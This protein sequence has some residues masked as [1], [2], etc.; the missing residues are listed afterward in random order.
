MAHPIIKNVS[1]FEH[2]SPILSSKQFILGEAH[3]VSVQVGLKVAQI[4]MFARKFFF[5]KIMPPKRK[6]AMPPTPQ[7]SSKSAPKRRRLV[8]QST[9]AIT[10]PVFATARA[11]TKQFLRYSEYVTLNPGIGQTAAYVFS[12]NGIYDPDITGVGHQVR[13][14]DQWMTLYTRYV[15]T[16]AKITVQAAN[17]ANANASAIFGVN[18]TTDTNTSLDIRDHTECRASTYA[19]LSKDAPRSVTQT[20]DLQSWKKGV[21]IMSDDVISGTQSSNPTEQYYFNVFVA[22]ITNGTDL[23]TVPLYVTIEYEV[24]MLDPDEPPIS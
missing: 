22:A 10:R 17:D 16:K 9:G 6:Y 19:V 7:M 20:F 12:A 15:V 21:K 11:S 2:G 4:K 23:A 14:F 8:K 18:V 3:T 24:V 13:G 1:L 5:L